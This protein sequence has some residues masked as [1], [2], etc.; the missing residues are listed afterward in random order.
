MEVMRD[1]GVLMVGHMVNDGDD[2]NVY[3]EGDDAVAG[4]RAQV[5]LRASKAI[6]LEEGAWT[7]LRTCY[8]SGYNGVRCWPRQQ[9]PAGTATE[10]GGQQCA[11]PRC[12]ADVAL[13][14]EDPA[15]LAQPSQPARVSTVPL[16]DSAM[17]QTIETHAVVAVRMNL[18]IVKDLREPPTLAFKRDV[19]E[20]RDVHVTSVEGKAVIPADAVVLG[21]HMARYDGVEGCILRSEHFR[22]DLPVAPGMAKVAWLAKECNVS[23]LEAK[24]AVMQANGNMS[25]ALAS[26]KRKR[27]DEPNQAGHHARAKT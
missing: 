3:L 25:A 26:T 11:C 2:P 4:S 12:K 15:M 22:C 13:T 27:G 16:V 5:W 14:S 1:A 10:S 21:M 19:D 18:Q 17:L 8:G 24:A 7:R 6:H 9:A 20:P 23:E